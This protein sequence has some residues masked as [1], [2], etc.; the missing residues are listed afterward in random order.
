MVGSPH[1]AMHRIFQHDPGVFA[2][3]VRALGLPFLDPTEV[4]L[5]PTDLTETRPLERRVDTLLRITTA[6]G[7][8]LLL[9][10]AQGKVD[11]LEPA[12]WAYY[13]SHLYAKYRL[14]PVLLIVCQDQKTARWARRPPAIGAPFRRS[15]IVHPIVLGPHNVPA[16]TDPRIAASD[17]PLAAL[18]AVTHANEPDIDAILNALARA[19]HG[20]DEDQS[21]FA[22]LTE[23]GLGTSPAAKTWRKLMSVDLSFFRSESSQRLRAEGRVEGQVEGVCESILRVL[24]RR[25]VGVSA[26]ARDR[27][28]ACDDRD[29]LYHWLDRA[30]VVD[31]TDEL[32][33]A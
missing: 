14:P 4:A 7:A 27:I 8:F 25:G 6:H 20:F 18:S 29:T 28:E 26:P 13:L 15:L 16:V 22:E 33:R 31:D 5:L 23:M 2:R 12:A 24:E 19:L 3:A 30:L 1:E 10:E 17:I 21:I 9:V 32:F 11:H